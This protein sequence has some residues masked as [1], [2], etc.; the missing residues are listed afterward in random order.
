[1]KK[2]KK[3]KIVAKKEIYSTYKQINILKIDDDTDSLGD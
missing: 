3:K 1:M 2:K